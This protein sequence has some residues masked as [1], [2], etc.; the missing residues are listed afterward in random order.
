CGIDVHFGLADEPEQ[1]RLLLV[2]ALEKQFVV[3]S[4]EWHV[5]WK[6][7]ERIKHVERSACGHN[8]LRQSADPTGHAVLVKVSAKRQC[9]VRIVN[10]DFDL[11][12]SERLRASVVQ[13]QIKI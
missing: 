8:A 10:R 13:E 1:V 2:C 3:Q 5:G 6:R 4:V 12:D 7:V 11:A 9:A